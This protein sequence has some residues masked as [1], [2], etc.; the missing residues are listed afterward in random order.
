MPEYEIPAVS[1]LPPK[2]TPGAARRRVVIV[3]NPHAASLEYVGPMLV[4]DETKYFFDYSGRSDLGYDV[5]FVTT[6]TGEVYTRKGL[7]I[8][9][10]T[11]YHQVRGKVD[12]LIFQASDESDACLSDERFLSW[13]AKMSGRVRRIVS[14]CTGSFILAQAGVLEGRHATTHW[15]ACNDFRKRF[16]R[17]KL[18]PD[19]I[20]TKDGNVY[21]S[22]GATA[23]TDLAIA[24]VEEDFGTEF[25]R[26]VAQG[27]V[28]YLRRPGNQAQFSVHLAS[29]FA[30]EP[31]IHDIQR[32]ISENLQNDLRVEALASQ[33][34]MSPRNFTRVFTKQIGM[35]PGRYVEQCRLEY[36]RQCLEQS[37]AALSHVA[38]RCG[39]STP[40]GL[41]L[42]FDRHLGV[43]PR[44]YR[45]RFSTSKRSTP[46]INTG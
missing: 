36:A 15:C 11:P 35:T 34:H 28:M 39:Y 26:R 10:T 9:A 12:T 29:R 4:F 21:T 40:D 38:R 6:E 41:R 45:Q 19:P 16:P 24:L 25:A 33:F 23:G 43:S 22:A 37:D 44:E 7:S 31:G 32:H 5:E 27:L 46:S 1:D 30:D 42:A 8:S 17:V 20:Y 13:V 18:D 14:I 3:T 2:G